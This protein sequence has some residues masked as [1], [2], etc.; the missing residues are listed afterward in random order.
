MLCSQHHRDDFLP[1]PYG[2]QGFPSVLHFKNDNRHFIFVCQRLQ[3]LVTNVSGRSLQWL[4]PLVCAVRDASP[5]CGDS[6]FG[7]SCP[8]LLPGCLRFKTGVCLVSE[9]GYVLLQSVWVHAFCRCFVVQL[10][11]RYRKGSKS[12]ISSV[13]S[14]VDE[15]MVL[16]V[17]SICR[18][19][20]SFF[21]VFWLFLHS[22]HRHHLGSLVGLLVVVFL[23]TSSLPSGSVSCHRCDR[24]ILGRPFFPLSARDVMLS[25][26]PW[27][28]TSPVTAIPVLWFSVVTCSLPSLQS[29]GVQD[30]VW[31]RW[32]PTRALDANSGPS[33]RCVGR[34]FHSQRIVSSSPPDDSRFPSAGLRGYPGEVVH[35]SFCGFSFHLQYFLSLVLWV[36]FQSPLPLTAILATLLVP[37]GLPPGLWVP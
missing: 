37:E 31:W 7:V 22:C 4:K 16:L 2:G 26:C 28:P 24:G 19:L 20:T 12:T 1:C 10:S 21:R 3:H 8:E 36:C 5:L 27:C 30:T 34:S 29:H 32:V 33:R 18:L 35:G 23:I 14:W 15:P 11:Q 6:G 17:A 25:T 9:R 13:G